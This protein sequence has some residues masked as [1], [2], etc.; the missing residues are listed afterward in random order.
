MFYN[1][2]SSQR[3]FWTFIK[4]VISRDSSV[5]IYRVTCPIHN[6]TYGELQISASEPIKYLNWIIFKLIF[7]LL[8][9]DIMGFWLRCDIHQPFSAYT[10]IVSVHVHIFG[11]KMPPL[12]TIY[13]TQIPYLPRQYTTVI[14]ELF[15]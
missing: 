3:F 1:K 15:L 14:K 7:T 9:L 5:S 6:G 4:D 11:A 2:K 8:K 13:R 12:K 10:W